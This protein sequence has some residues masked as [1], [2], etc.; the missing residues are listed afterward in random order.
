LPED[1]KVNVGGTPRIVVI[2]PGISPRFY[3]YETVGTLLV[4]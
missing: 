2:E 4:S 1:G 3:G